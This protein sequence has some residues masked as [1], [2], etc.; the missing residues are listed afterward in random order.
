MKHK[1]DF[2]IAHAGDDTKIA[3]KLYALLISTSRVF[4]DSKSLMLGDNWDQELLKAQRLSLITVVIVSPKTDT[5]YYQREEIAA[6]IRMA[7]SDDLEHRVIPIFMPNCDKNK[8]PYGLSIKHS[9]TLDSETEIDIAARKLLD[10][11]EKLHQQRKNK[12]V[13]TDSATANYPAGVQQALTE[14]KQVSKELLIVFS[15]VK[16][17]PKDC[18]DF[19]QKFTNLQALF[20]SVFTTA[21]SKM[22]TNHIAFLFNLEEEVS[23]LTAILLQ[24]RRVCMQ[25]D[26]ESDKLRHQIIRNVDNIIRDIDEISITKRK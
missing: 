6:A 14:A 10:V 19:I 20:N 25:I 2:F 17:T 8:T 18:D 16:I 9:L 21:P 23:N 1:W 15:R 12:T 7:R 26:R 24:Y 22:M 5:A 11:L 4:L 3:E 13:N